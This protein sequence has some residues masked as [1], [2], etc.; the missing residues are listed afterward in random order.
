MRRTIANAMRRLADK[1]DPPTWGLAGVQCYLNLYDR[2]EA[3]IQRVV[4]RKPTQ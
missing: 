3:V 1:I 4:L 2:M